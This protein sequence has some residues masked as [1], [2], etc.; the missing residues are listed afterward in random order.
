MALSP[1]VRRTFERSPVVRRMF[2]QW[3]KS[4]TWYTGYA[5]DQDRF[6]RFV[7][8]VVRYSR[9]RPEGRELESLMIQK[10][11]GRLAQDVLEQQARGYASLYT[12]LIDFAKNRLHRISARTNQR[13]RLRDQL[14]PSSRSNGQQPRT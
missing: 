1:I 9:R 11:K 4:E 7:W 10:W 5:C 3:I 12:R 13:P 6:Y 8:A 14:R 2:Q